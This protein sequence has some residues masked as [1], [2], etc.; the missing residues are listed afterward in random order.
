VAD[1][2]GSFR[3]GPDNGRIVL[4]TGR[5]GLAARAGHDLTIEVTRWSA[6]VDVPDGDAGG[7]TAA[8][9]TAE[10]DLGS[11]EVREGTGG[12]KPLTDRDR[13]DIRKTMS[14]I[15]GGGTASFASSRIVRSGASA[16]AIEGT[17][18]LGGKT[19]P[20]RL[21]ASEIGPGRYRAIGTVVQTAHGI[22]PYVGFF[23]ALKLRDEVGVE[24]EVSLPAEKTPPAAESA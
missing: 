19:E 24:V 22:K 23:G 14:G 15:L 12:A 17:L 2:T 5:A 13:A 21:Q 10:L 11:L 4:K 1:N 6:T 8:T 3:L 16:G 9:L 20:V 18:T 7:V